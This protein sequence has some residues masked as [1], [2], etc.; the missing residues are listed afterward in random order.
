MLHS[1]MMQHGVFD[2]FG[3]RMMVLLGLAV[4]LVLHTA[5]A[6]PVHAR[7]RAWL[8]V[9]MESGPNG[10]VVVRGVVHRRWAVRA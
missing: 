8:G 2:S 4:T 9:S 1:T 5:W 7:A 10:G 6:T 3:R